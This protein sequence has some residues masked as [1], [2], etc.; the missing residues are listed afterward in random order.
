MRYGQECAY[1]YL[2]ELIKREHL[3]ID[4]LLLVLLRRL[5][6]LHI[7]DALALGHGPP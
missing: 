1:I 6:F 4:D 7:G 2:F 3:F 5:F